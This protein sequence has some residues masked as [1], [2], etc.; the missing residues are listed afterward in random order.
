MSEFV[1]VGQ[2]VGAHGIKGQVKVN[3]LT[4]Y[5][6]RMDKGARLRLKGDWI[7]V[8]SSSVHKGRLLLK[9]AGVETM[10]QA[11]A[12]QWEYLEAPPMAPAE[13][14]EDEYLVTDLEGM[15]VVTTAGRELGVVDEVLPYPAQDILKVG[16]L[17]IPAVKEFVKEIDLDSG[18]ITVEL[19]PG[20]L[21][22]EEAEQA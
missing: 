18:V 5:L 9:L 4:E 16:D 8:E 20:M 15:R 12:L 22:E 21:P 6:E 17:M 13:M 11:Q 3:P 7:E 2:I 1:Q 10:T 14:E 19:I